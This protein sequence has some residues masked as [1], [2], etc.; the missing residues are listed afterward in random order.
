M[1]YL[2]IKQNCKKNGN[3]VQLQDLLPN[4]LTVFYLSCEISFKPAGI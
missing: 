2:Q 3:H 1:V 4:I